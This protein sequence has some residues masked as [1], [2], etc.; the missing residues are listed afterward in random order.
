MDLFISTAIT[1]IKPFAIIIGIGSILI[2]I[3]F[4]FDYDKMRARAFDA[5]GALKE[6][7]NRLTKATSCH[8]CQNH[9]NSIE[10]NEP[11]ESTAPADLAYLEANEA[12]RQL[13]QLLL[14]MR[15]REKQYSNRL[16]ALE[17]M[18]KGVTLL[19][20]VNKGTGE[21]LTLASSIETTLETLRKHAQA[22]KLEAP[23]HC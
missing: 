5:Y 4:I 21:W 19:N 13:S 11:T 6:E 18:Y 12:R 10:P 8:T 3:R 20:R 14:R 16:Y 17:E 23:L 1:Y 15:A 9:M 22:Y 7:L 2:F